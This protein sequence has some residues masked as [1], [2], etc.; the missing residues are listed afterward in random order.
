MEVMQM[1]NAQLAHNLKYL[2]LKHNLTQDDMSEILNI[3][4][5]AYSNYETSKRTPDL[6]TLMCLSNYYQVNLNDLVLCNLSGTSTSFEGM[7]EGEVPYIVSKTKKTSTSIYLS[8]DELE[9]ILKFRSLTSENKQIITN[10][11][12]NTK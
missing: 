4:R 8:E 3:S 7:S 11:I 9:M 12:F 6:D 5:Q 1:S 10:F 2:R